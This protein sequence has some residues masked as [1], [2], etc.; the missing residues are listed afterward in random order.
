MFRKQPEKNELWD[1][2]ATNTKLSSRS[3]DVNVLKRFAFSVVCRTTANS[4]IKYI[5]IE[6]LDYW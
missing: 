1:F 4:A 2:V 5:I 6:W 3:A